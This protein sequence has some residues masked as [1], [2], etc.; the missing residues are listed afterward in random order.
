MAPVVVTLLLSR[1]SQLQ[2]Q[3]A[4]TGIAVGA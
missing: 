3:L 4:A 2:H 1:E